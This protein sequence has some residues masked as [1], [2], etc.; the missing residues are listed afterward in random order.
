[1][2]MSTQ[3]GGLDM[4]KLII[5]TIV[6]LFGAIIVGFQNTTKQTSE[7]ST[8]MNDENSNLK[9]AT[10][11]GGCFWCVESDF[12][13]VDGVIKAVSGYTGGQMKNP[14]YKEVSAGGTGHVEAVQ[15]FY[16]PTI[17]TYKELLDV[18][19]KHVDPTDPGGQFVDRGA[20]YRTAIF[21]HDDDQR[22]IA[23]ASKK[24][25]DESG[26]YSKP[27]T[28]EIIVF[29]KF[30]EAE[31]YHQDYYKKSALRYKFYRYNSGR[32]QFLETVWKDEEGQPAAQKASGAKYAKPPDGVLKQ[33]LTPL[34][35]KV[36]RQ[37][38][39]E[40]SFKNEYWNNK[41]EGIYVDIVSGEPLFSSRDKFKSGTGW[42]SFTK[43]L[44]ADNIVEHQ[45][46]SLFMVRSEVR[47]KH[48]DSH[49]GHLFDDG[50]APTGLRYCINSA[51]LKFIPRQE[52]T[53]QG[54]GQY[55][56]TF[57]NK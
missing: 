55:A 23:L 19:W 7:K 8:T 27:I 4:K 56:N 9:I 15:V 50:P 24:E 14:T 28:T 1:M 39:T 12:E 47:S 44:D 10:V 53:T 30:Y 57:N 6:I 41:D 48:A 29:S 11:A 33:K 5:V 13:K 2:A 49:L 3:I 16:D 34:Q 42:P 21:Y 20:Q 36:A 52:L 38:G 54:Y 40:P 43:P 32:D 26:R 46:R 51:S 25:L 22:R 18:F 45:D 17:I 35:Y 31:E 37:D